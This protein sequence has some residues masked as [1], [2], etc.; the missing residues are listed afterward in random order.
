VAIAAVERVF[1][2]QSEFDPAGASR[3][4]TIVSSDYG[5]S[6]AGA[7]LVALLEKQ[8]PH[9][10]VH[11]HPITADVLSRNPEFSRTVDGILLPHGYL[12]LPRSVDLFHDEWICVVAEDNPDIGPR[13]TMADL[14]R[15]PW[16][17]T[18][19]DPL[20]RA[21]AWRQMELLGV[22]PRV[23]ATADSFL[24]MPHLVRRTGGI[25][26][27]QHRLAADI[28]DALGADHGAPVRRGADR[29]DLLVAPD[30]RRGFGAQL[31]APVAG[32]GGVWDRDGQRVP[33]NGVTAGRRMTISPSGSDMVTAES[34]GRSPLYR[35]SGCSTSGPATI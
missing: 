9:A 28:A 24:A 4:F 27:M 3:V 5:V 11:F 18:F 8:A 25:A 20:G 2:A 22:T 13:L 29:G 33:A 31:V 23:C 21:P 26:L 15:L 34:P 32:R 16:V 1:S 17:T 10:S 7:R 14:A 35:N 19:H 30:V 12:D 6:V